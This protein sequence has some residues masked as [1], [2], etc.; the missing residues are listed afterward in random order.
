MRGRILEILRAG[1]YVPEG[2]SL[3]PVK[4]FRAS[5]MYR[6]LRYGNIFRL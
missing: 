4:N 1:G 2:R 6:A 3:Y 5:L